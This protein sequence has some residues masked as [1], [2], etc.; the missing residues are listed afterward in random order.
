MPDPVN[1]NPANVPLQA[2]LDDIVA[3]G[4]DTMALTKTLG[5]LNK[6]IGFTT[7]IANTQEA[8]GQAA[9]NRG[10]AMKQQV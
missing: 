7:A 3:N 2:T 6:M 5:Q 4:Q 1:P 10:E 8:M 9:K